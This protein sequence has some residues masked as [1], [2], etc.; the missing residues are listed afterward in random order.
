VW[1]VQTGNVL[2]CVPKLSRSVFGLKST[3]VLLLEKLGD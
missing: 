2:K 3:T 1:G